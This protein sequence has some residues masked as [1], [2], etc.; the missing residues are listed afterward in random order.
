MGTVEVVEAYLRVFSGFRDIAESTRNS[1]RNRLL[2]FVAIAGFAILNG[3]PLWDGLGRV[4]FSGILLAALAAPWVLSALFAVVTHFIIDE[5][6]VRDDDYFV[7]KLTLIELQLE[8]ERA[9]RADPNNM[10]AIIND[11]H[12]DLVEPRRDTERWGNSAKWLERITFWL[13]IIGFLWAM[14][15]P[16]IL[17]DLAKYVR[18]A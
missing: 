1:A 12:S 17:A 14:T 8:A 6:K 13:L 3:N 18:S 15:G 7:K 11:T 16:F 5:A 9:N 2:W 4:H 10:K